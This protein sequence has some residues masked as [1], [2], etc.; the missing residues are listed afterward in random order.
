MSVMN[1]IWLVI[2]G[3]L[4]NVDKNSIQS[5][6]LFMHRQ[7]SQFA[8]KHRTIIIII[9]DTLFWIRWFC[10][11]HLTFCYF[12]FNT[13]KFIVFFHLHQLLIS[14]SHR[15]LFMW[16]YAAILY[17][18]CK[19]LTLNWVATQIIYHDL[20]EYRVHGKW[21]MVKL[22]SNVR[23]IICWKIRCHVYRIHCWKCW[24]ELKLLHTH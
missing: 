23:I 3:H 13:L 7:C 18:R 2:A 6:Q 24:N 8:K 1:V 9:T 14:S 4:K 19:V 22:Y 15:L 21:Q 17:A 16:N 20:I 5:K 11:S 12:I 10:Y